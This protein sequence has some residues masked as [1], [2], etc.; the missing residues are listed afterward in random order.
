M[1]SPLHK[2]SI[3]RLESLSTSFK[4]GPL[5]FGLNDATLQQI[6]G[7]NSEN[8]KAYLNELQLNG[9]SSTQLSIL[10]DAIIVTKS[11]EI[12]IED[13]FELVLSGPEVSGIPISDTS[14]TMH[15]LIESAKY[16][17]LLVGYAIHN[18]KLLFEHIHQK[19]ISNE[20]L[21]VTFCFNINRKQGDKSLESEIVLRFI[22]EFRER[23]W[24]WEKLPK[25]YYDPRALKFDNFHHSSLHAK[26]LVSDR[27]KALIT[28]ANFTEA[29]QERN[30]EL[31]ILI[32]YSP[33]VERIANYFDGLQINNVLLLASY[34]F[35]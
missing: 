22:K 15:S 34:D 5:S 31:G 13:I 10:I 33:I 1:K 3:Q 23:H 21:K 17:L 35:Y 29:A 2:L 25:V 32:R 14:A 26:C 20:S 9:F 28:S 11:Y 18:A 8:I 19:I 4:N 27:S 12:K 30:I 6:A 24:P 7:K 16:E